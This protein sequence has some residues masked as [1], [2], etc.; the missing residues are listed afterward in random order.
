MTKLREDFKKHLTLQRLSPR[1]HKAYLNAVNGLA[2]YYNQSPD[3]LS[4]EQIQ[5]Y[6]V[7]LL[8]NR[9]YAWSS[10]NVIFCGVK[11]FYEEILHRDTKVII[12]PRPRVKQ[13]PTVLSQKEVKKLLNSCKNLKHQTLLFGVYSAG[14]RVSEVVKLKPVHIERDRMMIR[15]EQ[16]KG[17]KDRYTILSELFLS[18]LIIYWRKYKPENYLFFGSCKTKPMAIGTAQKIYYQVKEKAGIVRNGGIHMLRHS[19]ATHLM[20]Q[21][22]SIYT[23]KRMMGHSSLSTT[24]GYIHVSKE[25]ISTIKSPLDVLEEEYRIKNIEGV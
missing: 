1:T 15:V 19:F 9:K 3:C 12:P 7:Y 4:D 11:K 17:R 13:I 24:A 16:G 8:K 2:V 20:E 25:F 10:C 18:K 23:I 22:V 6:F 14:L 5:N 21:K